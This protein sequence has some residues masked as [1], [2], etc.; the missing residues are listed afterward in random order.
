MRLVAELLCGA[1]DDAIGSDQP[2]QLNGIRVRLYVYVC[3]TC[4]R[5]ALCGPVW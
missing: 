1:K 4:K 2:I 5:F 3:S